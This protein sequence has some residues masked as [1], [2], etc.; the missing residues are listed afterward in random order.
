[1]EGLEPKD[2]HEDGDA[3]HEFSKRLEP[4]IG[5][6]VD[7]HE[8]ILSGKKITTITPMLEFSIDSWNISADGVIAYG[9]M[10]YEA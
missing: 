6:L 7:V 8:G 4:I 1:L 5:N 10:N 2:L 9:F 3:F